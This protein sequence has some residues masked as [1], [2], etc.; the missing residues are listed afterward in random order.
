MEILNYTISEKTKAEIDEIT[1]SFA[2]PVEYADMK[3]AGVTGM[4]AVYYN[5]P[6]KYIVFLSCELKPDDFET[7]L[8]CEL[9]HIR[10]VEEKYPYAYLKNSEVVRNE[11]NP[12][13]FS[14]LDHSIQSAIRDFDVI[15]RL[16]KWGHSTRLYIEKRLE[17]ILKIDKSSNMADKYNYA[18]FGIQYIMFCLTAESSELE[19]ARNFL[20]ENFDGI[21]DKIA[22]MAEKIKEIGFSTPLQCAKCLLY[23]IDSFN[24][25][26]V[27]IV[28]FEDEKIKTH[29][30]CVK[31]FEKHN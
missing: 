22:P 16:K 27:E 4:G 25:W 8:M 10:Q 28:V 18:S 1:K 17:Q 21:A 2:R 15:D 30:A 5:N 14:Y 29:N 31:F 24:L 6:E 7:N 12:M 26:D 19:T 3:E 23:V 20:N 9:N 11:Q 13:F